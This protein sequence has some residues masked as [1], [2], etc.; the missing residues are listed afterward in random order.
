MSKIKDEIIPERENP[1]TEEKE[2]FRVIPKM[3]R[4]ISE[5]ESVLATSKYR[6]MDRMQ[7]FNTNPYK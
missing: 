7:E 6:E 3:R 1:H 5:A 4:Y 2:Y